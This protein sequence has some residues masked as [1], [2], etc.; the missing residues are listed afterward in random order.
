MRMLMMR[1]RDCDAVISWMTRHIS[2]DVVQF[3]T[4][5]ITTLV[6]DDSR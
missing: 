1:P 3:D 2:A 4:C 5:T 6:I